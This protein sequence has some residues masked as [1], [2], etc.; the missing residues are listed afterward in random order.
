MCAINGFAL[1]D[2][3]LFT[4]SDFA[5]NILDDAPFHE[6]MQSQIIIAKICQL[7]PII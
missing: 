3:G 1:V 5:N 7:V 6:G 4:H 2:I